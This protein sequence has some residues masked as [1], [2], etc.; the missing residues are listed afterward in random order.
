MAYATPLRRFVDVDGTRLH[1]FDWGGDGPP[2][3]L[4]HATGFHGYVWEPIARAL[5]GR[6]RVVALD[7]RG[8]GDSVKPESGYAWEVFIHDLVGFVDELGL[9]GALGVGHS[10]G[11]TVIAG[12]A[13]E[14]PDLFERLV[15]VDMILFPREFRNLS[16]TD[17]PMSLAARK[18]REVWASRQ[19]AFESYRG[20][21]PFRKW[22]DEALRCY[23]DHG[24]EEENGAGARLKCPGHIEAQVFGMASRYDAW[25]TLGRIAVPTLLVRGSESDAFSANDA[26]EARSRLARGSLLTVPDTTHFVPMEEPEEVVRAIE[27]FAGARSRLPLETRGLAHVALDVRKLEETVRFYEKVFGM[28][29]VWRPD[30]DNVYLSSGRDNLALHRTAK[31][32]REE[33]SPLD[34]L[35]FL[36]DDADRVFAAAEALEQGGVEI[37][38]APQHHRDG[39]CSVYVRDPDGNV[40]QV[41]YDP[42]AAKT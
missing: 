34:H 41:L 1:Y 7:A 28:R 15:L 6:Y 38:K 23:V 42:N 10:L 12:A 32:R 18:R 8:H 19:E 2:A 25:G 20:R 17:N 27:E 33:G 35:G 11:G 29:V 31:E 5:S 9:R 16:T 14:R 13:A 36:V 3:V 22:R 4:H 24:V 40:V 37:V 21:G 30:A 39:S 26:E